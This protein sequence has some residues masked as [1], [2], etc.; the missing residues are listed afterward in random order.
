M[1]GHNVLFSVLIQISDT[2]LENNGEGSRK[3]HFPIRIFGKGTRSVN[4]KDPPQDGGYPPV[5]SLGLGVPPVLSGAGWVWGT[6]RPV[7]G[8]AGGRN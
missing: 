6:P 2:H 3:T 8:R 4:K 5:L 7:E 1:Y